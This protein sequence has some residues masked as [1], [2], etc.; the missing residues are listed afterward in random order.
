MARSSVQA[1]DWLTFSH[2][3]NSS[4]DLEAIRDFAVVHPE[5]G[6]GLERYLKE[7]AWKDETEGL[8]RTYLVRQRYTGECVGYFSLK[9][10]LIAVN[11]RIMQNNS[12]AFDT[13]P[14]VELANFAVNGVF[15]KKYRISHLGGSIFRRLI[16]PFVQ[17]VSN[18]IGIYLI[19]IF[20]LPHSRLLDTY[21][22]YGFQ[23]LSIQAEDLLH[24]RLKPSY[25]EACIFMY[26]TLGQLKG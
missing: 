26:Q 22:S 2:L 20:A 16:I 24:Q 25:D 8:M 5:T 14:G 13:I 19:Y 7:F 21:H 11:E 9:A 15:R 1:S 10:G 3:T 4:E 23:R 6:A 18:S 12:V 17:K